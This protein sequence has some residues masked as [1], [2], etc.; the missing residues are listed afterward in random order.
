MKAITLY[1][2]VKELID[3]EKYDE[4]I[5]LLLGASDMDYRPSI[6]SWNLIYSV[7]KCETLACINYSNQK[8]GA[9]GYG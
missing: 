9:S 8:W 7:F 2:K 4:V 5:M 1:K 6:T 3:S